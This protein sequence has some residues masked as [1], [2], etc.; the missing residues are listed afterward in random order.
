MYEEQFIQVLEKEDLYGG[1]ANYADLRFLFHDIITSIKHT[2][3][4]DKNTQYPVQL[5]V[6]DEDFVKL[7]MMEVLDVNEEKVEKYSKEDIINTVSK[8]TP[9]INVSISKDIREI[10]EIYK[11][12]R[13]EPKFAAP[14]VSVT[15]LREKGLIN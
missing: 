11:S 13:A 3:V 1:D 12:M 6:V 5:T 10:T 8:H 2:N 7:K 4:L 9:K 15:E 14:L